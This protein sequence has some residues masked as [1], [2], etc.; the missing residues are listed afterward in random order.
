MFSDFPA[1]IYQNKL[2]TDILKKVKFTDGFKKS[3][4]VEN[5]TVKEE[6]SPESL[7][8]YLYN[9]TT[10]SWIILNLNDIADRNTEWPYSY[11]NMEK[12]IQNKY[13]GSSVFIPESNI[14]FSFSDVSS[15]SKDGSVYA[16]SS[17]DRSINK[18]T[19]SSRITDISIDDQVTVTFKDNTT[20]NVV[21]GRV[22]YDDS[23]SLHHFQDSFGEYLDPR[24]QDNADQDY[25]VVCDNCLN[26]YING[27]SEL[28]TITNRDYELQL[29]D[30]KRQILLMRPE[31]F[32]P[33]M[34]KMKNL[35]EKV[36]KNSNVFDIQDTFTIGD[37]SE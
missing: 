5:Y 31:Y 30:E 4:Y 12:I 10:F 14:N 35:F 19:T 11:L 3:L 15:I 20:Q 8:F 26:G 7:S 28:Y 16:I 27:S 13:S 36:E 32:S 17:Y 21:L 1:T 18:L 22:V 23:F 33:L 2:V 24:G 29:N 34:N 6:D 37:L 9:D 25:E